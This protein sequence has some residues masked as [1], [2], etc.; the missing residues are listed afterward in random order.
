[1]K[2]NDTVKKDND[3]GMVMSI[4]GDIA[5][6]WWNVPGRYKLEPCHID[7]LEKLLSD[8]EVD[9]IV[10]KGNNASDVEIEQ[11]VDWVLDFKK[12]LDY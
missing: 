9:D 6:I 5:Y 8:D 10:D 12:T 1:M 2:I 4:E 7:T 3:I 11:L